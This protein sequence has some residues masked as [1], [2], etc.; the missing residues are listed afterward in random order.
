MKATAV[1]EVETFKAVNGLVSSR[2]GRSNLPAAP[3]RSAPGV[4]RIGGID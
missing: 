2:S 4:A 1:L 3:G